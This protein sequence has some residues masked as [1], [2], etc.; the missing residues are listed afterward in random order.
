M[1]MFKKLVAT[2]MLIGACA[3]AGSATA[4]DM[5]IGYTTMDLANPYFIA[6]TSGVKERAE[7]LGVKVTI[8]DAKSDPASQIAAIENFIAQGMDAIVISPI[9]AIAVEPMVKLAHDNN[10]P[11]INAHQAMEGADAQIGLIEFEYGYAVGKLAGEYITKHMAGKADVAILGQPEVSALV[12]RVSGIKQGVLDHAPGATIAAEQS[13]YT[14]ETGARAA[15]VVMQSKPSVRV[16]VGMNDAGILGAFEALKGM[17]VNE[18]EFALFGLDA[19]EEAQLKIAQ[20][21][22]YKGTVDIAPFV[23]GEMIVDVALQVAKNGPIKDMVKIEMFPLLS[24]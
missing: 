2:S 6:V 16:F 23:T 4:K 21:T 14:P 12:E 17:G 5:K 19:T 11:I 13:G 9:D 10:I 1:N 22:M 20:K 15:E 8:H 7:T 18:E 3:V 24:E